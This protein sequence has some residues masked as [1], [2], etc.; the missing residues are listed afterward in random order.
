MARH[1]L[2]PVGNDTVGHRQ[3]GGA[4]RLFRAG[5][6]HGQR[7]GKDA[8][9]GIGHPH[10]FQHPLHAAILTPAAVKGVETDIRLDLRQARGKVGAGIQL[11][12]L[13]SRLPKGCGAFAPA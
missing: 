4:K 6:V 10:P 1:H 13:K 2:I 5:L 11:D 9:M 12:H 3:A 7:R 8:R